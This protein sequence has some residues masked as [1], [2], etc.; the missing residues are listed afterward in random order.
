MV[1]EGAEHL[2]HPQPLQYQGLAIAAIVF[3]MIVSFV[4]YRHNQSAAAQVDSSALQTNALHFLA[5]VM[6]S[7][8]VIIALLVVRFTGWLWVDAGMAFGVAAYI[9]IISAKQVKSAM[10]E[11]LDVQLPESEIQVIRVVLDSFKDRGIQTHD[12]RTRR[13]GAVR[14]IDFH[15]ICCG[16]MTVGESHAV[17]DDMEEKLGRA[18]PNASVN[19]HVEPCEQETPDCHLK[20]DIYAARKNLR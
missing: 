7:L 11:L 4:M 15:M 19:I 3:S 6:A 16:K 10:G 20:C 14:H 5:D 1:Y 2:A 12:L 18:F 13:S 17:C 8:A 9:L